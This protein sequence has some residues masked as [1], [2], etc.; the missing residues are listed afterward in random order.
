M[1]R[2]NRFRTC[3]AWISIV[4][5]SSLSAVAA[6]NWPQLRGPTG[7]GHAHAAALPLRWSETQNVVW[8]TPIHGRAWSSPVVWGGQIWMTTATEDGRQLSVVCV[9]RDSGKVVHDLKLF[10]VS[11]PAE[12]HAFNS[13]A[14]PTAVIEAGRVYVHFGSEGTAC[15]DTATGSVLWSRRDLKCD[16]YR[17]PGSSAFLYG[18]LLILHFDGI[19]VQ[20]LAALDKT[21]GRTVWKTHRAVDYGGI[22]GDFRKAYATPIVIDVEGQPQLISPGAKATMAYD[23]RSGEE[24]W[25]VA[26]EG[27]S[28]AVMPLYGHGL[29]FLNTGFGKPE[30]WA[31]KPN[32][33]GDVTATHVVWKTRKSIPAKPTPVL[34]GD[35]IFA[36]DD[37]GVASCIDATSGET[38]WQKRIGGRHSASPLYMAGRVYFFDDES[39]TTVIE[40]GREFKQLAVNTLDAGCMASPAAVDRAIYLRTKTHLYRLEDAAGE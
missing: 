26:Y 18:D 27:F 7:D 17:G 10:D 34:V 13:Y 8:K 12:I 21:T 22:D 4:C 16:H 40:P 28:N 33:R 9:D 24:I 29:V 3:L 6:E 23:P 25:R 14:S 11:E 30:L 32:G 5:C 2:S 15:L 38:V 1:S 31:V 20:F 36:C 35:L 19:D 39:T 37:K